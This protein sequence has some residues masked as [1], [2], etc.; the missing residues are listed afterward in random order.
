MQNLLDWFEQHSFS[1]VKDGAFRLTEELGISVKE[2]EEEGLFVLNYSQINSPKMHP[3]VIECR[4]LIVTN[5]LTP[6]CRP[7]DRF[8]NLGEALEITEEF[9]F[10]TATFYEKADGSLAKVYYHDD[11]WHVATRGTAFAESANYTSEVFEDLMME[12]FGCVDMDDFQYKMRNVPIKY[13]HIFEYTSPKNRIVTP[14]K[15]H[16][17]VLLGIRKNDNGNDIEL[18]VDSVA[19]NMRDRGL[20]VRASKQ[21]KF[22]SKE[23]MLAAVQSL[24]DLQE[25]FVGVDGKGV[26]VK[27]KSDLYVQIHKLR[28]DCIPTPRRISELVV[29]N[30]TEEYLAYFPE[31]RDMFQPYADSLTSMLAAAE[32]LYSRTCDIEDQKEFALRVKDSVYAGSL[33]AARKKDSNV[34]DEFMGLEVN[35]RSKVLLAY[36]GT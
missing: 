24:P 3:V 17:M 30:E 35:K 14:Y 16:E 6:V 21:Y 33:F 9:D 25:G 10:D 32:E 26:R 20:N 23:E 22:S 13:T 28:G 1:T 27:I 34:T 2:Y 19:A 5:D 8:F 15:A 36:K 4:G 18:M 12:A 7:F 11:G 31:D 29:T